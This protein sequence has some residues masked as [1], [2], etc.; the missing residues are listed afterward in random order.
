MKIDQQPVPAQ[1]LEVWKK[2]I[3]QATPAAINALLGQHQEL[4]FGFRMGK[5]KMEVAR[6]RIQGQLIKMGELPPPYAELLRLNTLAGTLVAVLSQQALVFWGAPI[7]HCFGTEAIV[8]A[9]Y[10]DEREEV[11]ALAPQWLEKSPAQDFDIVASG[12]LPPDKARIARAAAV[13]FQ[14]QLALLIGHLQTMSNYVSVLAA[15]KPGAALANPTPSTSTAIAPPLDAR[16]SANEQRLTQSLRSKDKEVKH[17]RREFNALSDQHQQQ[18]LALAAAQHALQEAKTLAHT[19]H[20]ERTALQ[21]QWEA[22]V[23]RRVSALLDERLLPWLRPA[24]VLADEVEAL[25]GN[26]KDLLKDADILLQRQ[27][28]QDRLYGL[29]SK[30]NAE[31]Q[32]CQDAFTRIQDARREALRPLPELQTLAQR[33]QARIDLIEHK[34]HQRSCAAVAPASAAEHPL[35]ER[36]EQTLAAQHTLDGVAEVRRT[37]QASAALGWLPE[38]TLAQAYA[39]VDQASVQRYALATIAPGSAKNEEWLRT[40]SLQVLQT[41]LAQGRKTTLVVD[42]HNVLYTQPA[43]FRDWHDEQGQ[44]GTKARYRLI[45]LLAGIAERYP[46]LEVHLWF[47]GPIL[48]DRTW[49]PNMRVHYSGGDGRDRADDCILS[50][51]RYLH[52]DTAPARLRVLVT[53]DQGEATQAEEVGALLLAPAQLLWWLHSSPVV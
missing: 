16:R 51:L 53:A 40:L 11:R 14:E 34:L 3:A 36:I 37:L 10:L 33:L 26:N 12:K 50:Y 7:C 30:L 47:D 18:A 23:A 38:P 27:T 9:L 17:Q 8:A 42:G 4:C 5:V 22:Q 49:A 44:P 35:L 32:S 41:E 24:E 48:A 2:S 52:S 21:A 1:V 45:K 28:A 15:A 43:E 13:T 20:T 6:T 46:T 39:L 29:R 25:S 19:A 31:L